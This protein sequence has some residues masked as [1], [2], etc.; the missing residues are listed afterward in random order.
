MTPDELNTMITTDDRH[1][2]YRGR[3]RILRATLDG[4]ELPSPCRILDAGCGSGRTLDEL[5][6]YG[7]ARGVDLSP[8]AVDAT[9]ARGHDADV[10]SVEDLPFP[11]GTFD[12]VTCLDVVEHTPDDRRTLDE[13]RRVTRPGGTLLL[14]VP[15]HP[16]LWSAH[17][18]ANHHYRR[19]TRGSLVDAADD[20]GWEVR[21]ATYFNAALLA[22]AAVLRVGRRRSPSAR[23]ELSLTPAALDRLLE[24]PSR[25]EAA[26]LRSGARL[27]VG[28]S[29][30]AVLRA[31]GVPVTALAEARA[32]PALAA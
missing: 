21:D 8:A 12:L 14:T 3:R 31:P 20:C 18:E 9:R 13:L 4:L 26:L 17:D 30:L 23:S 6:E 1:W 27:P 7:D 5:A 2:W 15:A 25:A 11:Y 22:P 24:L 10:A 16:A 19:Y 32:R 28:L 29:L